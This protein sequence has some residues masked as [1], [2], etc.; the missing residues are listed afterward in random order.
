MSL[1]QPLIVNIEGNS[2][3]DG[4]GIRSVIF[5][6]GCPLDCMWCHN[7]ESKKFDAELWWDNEKCI[8]CAECIEV[9]SEKAI[10]RNNI[11]FIDRQLCKFHFNC[12]D[13]CPS[14]ALT[15][16]G[17]RMSIEEIVE[18]VVKYK[19]FFDSSKG[20]VTFSGGEATLS[21][22]FTSQ[23]AKRLKQ[24]G[25]HVLLETSGQFDF[26]KF[27]TKLLP[28][29]DMVYYDIKIIDN[30]K[31][32]YYCGV[33]NELILDNF[34]KLYQKSKDGEFT[35][36]SRTPLIPGITD[37]ESNI[38]AIQGFYSSLGVNKAILLLNN[39]AWLHKFK[40]LGLPNKFPMDSLINKFYDDKKKQKL[41]DYFF[42]ND[43]EISFN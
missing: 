21:I 10:S 20:G 34:V 36:L 9:C 3:D 13:V 18:Q 43:I 11:F 8:D 22:E 1:K 26:K 41:I 32:S 27:E 30:Q 5:F 7:P 42:E 31:H 38:K 23:L 39:P 19:P 29:L 15:R 14:N 2:F 40:K 25:I 12:I 17:R 4:P 33:S 28:Y 6:K 37:N 16:V 35:L 24:E